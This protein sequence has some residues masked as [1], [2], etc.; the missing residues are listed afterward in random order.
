MAGFQS[1]IYT[2]R[3]MWAQRKGIM[4]GLPSLNTTNADP[5]LGGDCQK[6]TTAGF[7]GRL[8][9]DYKGRY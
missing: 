7:F 3:S 5:T 2:S 1:E 8:N 6:W 9:Y 4:A